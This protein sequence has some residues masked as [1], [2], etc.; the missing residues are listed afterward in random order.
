MIQT[1]RRDNRGI[2][3]SVVCQSQYK[4]IGIGSI[5]VEL[6]QRVN[7]F[8]TVYLERKHETYEGT[9][10]VDNFCG[11]EKIVKSREVF[12]RFTWLYIVVPFLC[13][14]LC[15]TLVLSHIIFGEVTFS[16]VAALVSA[17]IL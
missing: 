12:G 8:K 11:G 16:L 10:M 14:I 1:T 17:S 6:T 4:P 2:T 7:D 3:D 5:I 9:T 15:L 13:P